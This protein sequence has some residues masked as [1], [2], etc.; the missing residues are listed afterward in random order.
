MQQQPTS[1]QSRARRIDDDEF[2]LLQL[3]KRT[4]DMVRDGRSSHWRFPPFVRSIEQQLQQLRHKPDSDSRY[5]EYEERL[6]LLFR[7]EQA[8]RS[9]PSSTSTANDEA[10]FT[11]DTDLSTLA[12]DL[13]A[14]SSVRRLNDELK[15]LLNTQQQQ[16]D[17]VTP[18][19]TIV[20]TTIAP[21]R[22]P[23]TDVERY[24]QHR[25]E[26]RNRRELFGAQSVAQNGVETTP[27]GSGVVDT[28]E[29]MTRQRRLQE[30]YAENMVGLVGDIRQHALAAQDVIA[31]DRESL[32]R[33]SVQADSNIA[34]LK[35]NVSKLEQVASKMGNC[36]YL[37]SLVVVFAVFVW[38]VMLIRLF[39]K[40][41][42]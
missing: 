11:T 41:I 29:L 28:S 37:F 35:A 42:A 4:E 12:D 34:G 26:E 33:A 10:T 38:M 32:E 36:F 24:L 17:P 31:K 25:G 23:K 39:P 15:Q 3:L 20:E 19:P 5:D 18:N 13:A 1:S 2:L 16:R 22:A 21:N 30:K 27:S 40:P 9:C 8:D 14:D 6:Q 7:V